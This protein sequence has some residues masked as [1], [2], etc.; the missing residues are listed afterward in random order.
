MSKTLHILWLN[1][2]PVTA[3]FMVFMYA[4]NSLRR[5]WWDDVHLI[6]WGATVQLVC[7]NEKM[8]ELVKT[9]QAEG[10]DVSACLRCAELL[11]KVEELEAIGDI[12]I[13]LMGEPLT[14]I[15]Q[16]D[17]KLITL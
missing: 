9:F 4:T 2:N 17:D 13:R 11:G 14:H 12:D 15:I 7:E 6:L 16:G 5:G 10:G 8:R 1:D 3:E